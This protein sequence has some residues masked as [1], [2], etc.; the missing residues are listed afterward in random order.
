MDG[1]YRD[2]SKRSYKNSN[3]HYTLYKKNTRSLT[4]HK[5]LLEVK[6]HTK[7]EYKTLLIKFFSSAAE[8]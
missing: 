2:L 7:F 5:M 3:D 4:F 6:C 8:N 1:Y